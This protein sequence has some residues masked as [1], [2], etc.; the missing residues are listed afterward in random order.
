MALDR[1]IVKNTLFGNFNQQEPMN[2][3]IK[4]V[5]IEVEDEQTIEIKKFLDGKN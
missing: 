4:S 1:D 2:S 5:M 3:T